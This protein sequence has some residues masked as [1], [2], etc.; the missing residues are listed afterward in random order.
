[1]FLIFTRNSASG[2]CAI[3]KPSE[4]APKSAEL[5]EKLWPKYFDSKTI[6]LVNGGVDKTT[7]LLSN[8]FDHIFYTGNT[9][10]GKI[11]M[12]AA[13]KVRH[14]INVLFVLRQIKSY[15]KKQQNVQFKKYLTPVTLECGGKSPVYIDEN[16]D[17]NVVAKRITWGKFANAGQT[18]VAPDY[19]LCSEQTR[20][21]L[22]SFRAIY[23]EQF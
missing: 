22:F 5:L 10:V 8:R 17:L 2:N 1:M 18:C 6:A 4:L 20:V 13:S 21:Q 16:V 9:Q 11:I 12:Q 3:V 23:C 14:T 19:I 7:E 15:G